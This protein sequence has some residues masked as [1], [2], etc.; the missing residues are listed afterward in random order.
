MFYELN[1]ILEEVDVNNIDDH[2]LTFG[3]ISSEEL[4]TYGKELGFDEDTINASQEANKLFRTGVDVHLEYTFA[5]LKIVNS[6]N[7]E[8]YVS[9]FIKKN[10]LLI[11]DIV[12]ED[13]STINAFM[14]AIKKYPS[15]K[16]SNGRLIYCFIDSLLADANKISEEIRN[17]L[18]DMEE[19]IV[20]GRVNEE[21][22]IELLEL[23]KRILKFYNF[24]AQIIDISETLEEND[25][26]ILD[27]D[28]IIYI[29]NLYNKVTRLKDDM[30]TLNNIADHIQDA[31]ATYLD[32]KMNN[33]MKIFTIITTIFFPLTIIVG[34]YGMNFQNMPEL[35]WKF[36]Y[37]YVTVLSIVVVLILVLI[38]KKKK[39]F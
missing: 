27:D 13:N 6:D 30:N 28:N 18:T 9:L 20:K 16:I 25:N 22:N 1:E 37:L 23:K 3:C 34:W 32:Q 33:T 5:E 35:Y 8:D 21:F 14:K 12:D 19:D 10:L 24:Y 4:L 7:H 38:G 31:Y 29:T 36:G 17:I 15:H 39:W 2:K 11:V 26:E